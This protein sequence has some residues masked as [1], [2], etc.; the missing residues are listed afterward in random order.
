MTADH[1]IDLVPLLGRVWETVDHRDALA[2]IVR[3]GWTPC[4]VGDW[5]VGLRSPRGLLAARICPFDPAYPAFLELC[6]RCPGNPYLP[7]VSLTEALDGGGSLTVLEF[8]APAE[9][10]EAAAVA[11]RWR[12]GTG[13]EA[14]DAVR[15]TA[16]AV[17]EE[18]RVR[19]PWWDGIDLNSGNVRRAVDGR[20]VLIDVFCMDGASLYRQVLDDSAV[21]RERLSAAATRHLLDIPFIARESSPAEIEALRAAWRAGDHPVSGIRGGRP[22]SGRCASPPPS[23]SPAH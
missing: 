6:R 4:G 21:V 3:L 17:D 13:D 14:F 11:R 16:H 20:I 22:G 12:E 15:T 8:L 23:A 7:R 2:E 9:E 19:M 1:D 10:A 18:W 5:A